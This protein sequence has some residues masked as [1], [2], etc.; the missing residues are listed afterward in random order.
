MIE[1]FEI[2]TNKEGKIFGIKNLQVIPEEVII[3]A[4]VAVDF[5]AGQEYIKDY[6]DAIIKNIMRDVNELE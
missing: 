2:R 4:D 5:Q 6:V 3:K 1:E